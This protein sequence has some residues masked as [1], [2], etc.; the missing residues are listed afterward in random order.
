MTLNHGHEC[1][2]KC[3]RLNPLFVTWLMG[4]PGGWTQL[5]SGLKDS[6]SLATE[7][8]RWS[9]LMRYSLSRLGH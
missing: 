2:P 6:E 7:W 1:S 9:Q 3:R 4:W 8:F 5:P